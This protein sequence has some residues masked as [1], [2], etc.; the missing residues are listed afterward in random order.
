LAVSEDLG[1]WFRAV[2]QSG[3]Q[4]MLMVFVLT[5][6]W[7]APSAWSQE[8]GP[9]GLPEQTAV[10]SLPHAAE[11]LTTI[12]QPLHERAAAN[13]TAPTRFNSLPIQAQQHSRRL[14]QVVPGT[15][16]PDKLITP[17]G[18]NPYF[19]VRTDGQPYILNMDTTVNLTDALNRYYY[20]P[21]WRG[22]VWTPFDQVDQIEKATRLMSTWFEYDQ[23]NIYRKGDPVA[24][25]FERLSGFGP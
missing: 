6:M 19:P 10:Q 1:D 25:W 21:R 20:N 22:E 24:K 7:A 4:A 11:A 17:P 14:A 12:P 13:T 9:Q 18:E 8:L 2:K 3:C 16:S 5:Q 15:S 23:E